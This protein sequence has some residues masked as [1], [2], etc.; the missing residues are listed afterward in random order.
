MKKIIIVLAAIISV[1]VKAQ[2]IDVEQNSTHNFSVSVSNGVTVNANGYNWS[3]TPALGASFSSTNTASTS[4]TFTGAINAT[5]SISVYAVSAAN[6]CSGNPQTRNFR[7]VSQLGVSANLPALS[8]ICPQTTSNPTGGDIPSFTI[9]FVDQSSNPVNVSGFSYQIVDP[10]NVAGPVTNVTVSNASSYNLDIT[11]AYNN[12][13]TGTYTIRIVSITP[14]VGNTVF[15]P[16]A[17]GNYPQ[18]TIAVNL[19]PELTW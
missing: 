15:Y 16:N 5:G 10:S 19:A 7:I 12:T 11:T 18:T 2:T 17:S 13:Q 8:A 4:V 6:S 14:S 9:Q 1:G 3:A